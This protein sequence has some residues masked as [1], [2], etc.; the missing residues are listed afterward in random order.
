[1]IVRVEDAHF[2]CIRQPDHATLA[3]AL[4]EA[5]R[6]D[7]LPARGTRSQVVLATRIH[8][9]GWEDEDAAPRLDPATG[10]P[11]DFVSAPL[12]VRQGIWPRAI[13]T[14]APRD[15][16]VAALVAQHALTIFRRYQHDPAWRGF[17]PPIERR[18]DDL[19][20][21]AVQRAADA[22]AE[23]PL[24]FLQDYSLVGIGDLFS[25]VF[26]NGW[27]APHLIERYQA[28]LRDTV[29]TIMPDPFGGQSVALETSAR[30]LPRRRYA[31]DADLRAAWADAE[32]VTLTGLAIGAPVGDAASR[33]AQTP[34]A[35]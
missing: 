12:E 28:I 24:S 21:E 4:I 1:M 8:D 5:W 29:L 34:P 20:A 27:T 25:L 2:V 22:G 13:A 3:G 17:F 10:G 26:C 18:R 9:V 7:G 19:Y 23:T 11:F 35:S 16:Y 15:P 14:L 32:L 6:A 31:S 30:R 33:G